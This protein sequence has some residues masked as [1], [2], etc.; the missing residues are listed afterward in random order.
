MSPHLV[1]PIPRGRDERF[2]RRVARKH[3]HFVSVEHSTLTQQSS[4]GTSRSTTGGPSRSAASLPEGVALT[5]ARPWD[6]LR[7]YVE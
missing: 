3:V 6:G 7:Q 1:A 4:R 2:A 5:I